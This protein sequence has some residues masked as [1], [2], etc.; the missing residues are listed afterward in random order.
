MAYKQALKLLGSERTF[1]SQLER[2]GKRMFGH[3][4]G[5]VFSR[6]TMPAVMQQGRRGYIVNTDTIQGSGVHWIAAMDIDGERMMSDPLGKIGRAQ[7]K[8]LDTLQQ[9]IWSEDDPEM[10][11]SAS[12][13]GPRSLAAL[14]V[15]LKLGKDAFLAL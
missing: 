9:P 4:F 3:Q 2:A 15:G 7:R 10:K 8:E 6:D 14:A 5:G 12:T 1:S 11:A 13:C